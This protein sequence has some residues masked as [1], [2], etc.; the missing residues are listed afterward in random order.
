MAVRKIFISI[1]LAL[2]VAAVRAEL[3]DTFRLYNIYTDHMV[4]QSG[5]NICISGTAAPGKSVDVT[6]DGETLRSCAGKNGQWRAI[7]SPRKPGGPYT[8]TVTGKNNVTKVLKDIMVGEVW[9]CSGQSNMAFILKDAFNWEAEMKTAQNLPDL[10]IFEASRIVSFA[11]KC[12]DVRSTAG[13]QRINP[14]LAKWY[15]AIGFLFGRDL[16]KKLNV[17]VGIINSSWGGTAIE[18]W[19]ST[20]ALRSAGRQDLADV[21]MKYP[22]VDYE[23]F[24][25]RRSQNALRW[26]NNFF[27]S[28]AKEFE[29]AKSWGGTTLV[30]PEKWKNV[31]LPRRLNELRIYRPGITWFR[32]E[33]DVPADMAGRDLELSLGPVGERDETMFNGVPVGATGSGHSMPGWVPRLYNIPGYLVNAGKNVVAVRVISFGTVG[34]FYGN[35][36]RFYLACEPRRITLAGNFWK[37]RSEFQLPVGFAPRPALAYDS[38]KNYPSCI[39]NASLAG[40]QRFPVRGVLWYQGEGNVSR[41]KEYSALF[42]SLITSWRREWND[43]DMHFIFAQLSSLERHA[44]KA[45]LP[46]GFYDKLPCRESGWAELREAQSKALELPNTAMVVTTD[47]GNPLDIHPRDK[48][49]VAKRMLNEALRIAYKEKT[50]SF[51]RFEKMSVSGNKV[52]VHFANADSGLVAVNGKLRRFAV[53]GS[54]GVFHWADAVIDHN[55]VILTCKEVSSPVYV[56]YAWDNNPID[57][58]LF[59]KEGLP[60]SGFRT[61][62]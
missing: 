50:A 26:E 10:R 30:E 2:T 13:W 25:N 12:D 21:S 61:G 62:R 51:P 4:L 16:N 18:P 45:K 42:K 35:P 38:T 41:A 57:A 19:M 39:Y 15:S 43:P 8:I 49:T 59:N 55:K 33:V 40:L 53:A 14:L 23:Q 34:G 9:V 3:A 5:K 6:F 29:K 7:F 28:H 56:R 52:I 36:D 20:D 31:T 11:E 58:N 24:K 22:A 37:M 54:D 32:C 47:V 60:A 46:A 17:P 48:Q 44:P 1:L 27:R